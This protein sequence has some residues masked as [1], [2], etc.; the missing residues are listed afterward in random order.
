M[1]EILII[2]LILSVISL[3]VFIKLVIDLDKRIVKLERKIANIQYQTDDVLCDINI[4][5]QNV[6][7]TY[8]LLSQ[9]KDENN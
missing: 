9:M 8:G 7:N 2:L 6:L 1:I 3:L 5:N 4:V